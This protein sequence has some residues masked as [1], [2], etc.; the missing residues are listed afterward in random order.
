V[1]LFDCYHVTRS[2]KVVDVWPI[3]LRGRCQ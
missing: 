2:G 1:N 3:D